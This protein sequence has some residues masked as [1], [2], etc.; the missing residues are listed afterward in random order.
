MQLPKHLIMWI[1]HDLLKQLNSFTRQ[2]IDKVTEVMGT[3]ATTIDSFFSKFTLMEITSPLT[4]NGEYV[5]MANA[6]RSSFSD[7]SSLTARAKNLSSGG[8][9][10]N[11]IFERGI[12]IEALKSW[13]EL[14]PLCPPKGV[15]T[16][17]IINIITKHLFSGH[18]GIKL[19][20][21]ETLERLI[22]AGENV[23]F[24]DEETSEKYMGLWVINAVL[25]SG[26]KLIDNVLC[27]LFL[28]F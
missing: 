5:S 21:I 10:V 13:L 6:R 2:L 27:F 14:I 22:L 17:D 25:E 1:D 24:Y 4:F 20:A 19:S 23:S 15:P 18:D 16:K 7:P 3:L 28:T 26:F 9:E 8:P 11:Q 12:M